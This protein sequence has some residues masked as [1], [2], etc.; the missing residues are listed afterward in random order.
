MDIIGDRRKVKQLGNN[1]AERIYG[2]NVK[3][4]LLGKKKNALNVYQ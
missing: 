1:P 3:I 2:Q 4:L